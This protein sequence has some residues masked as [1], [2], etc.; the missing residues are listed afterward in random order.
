MTDK[1]KKRVRELAKKS[2][3]SYQAA[4]QQ[5]EGSYSPKAVP[6]NTAL[7]HGTL[8]MGL[9]KR[10]RADKHDTDA[11]LLERVS[12]LA[13]QIEQLHVQLAGCSVAAL[14][15]AKGENDAA[16]G[17]YG[18][19]V[20]FDDVKALRKRHEEMLS[21]VNVLWDLLDDIDTASDIVKGNDQAYRNLVERIQKKRWDTGVVTDGYRIY[22][23]GWP[24]ERAVG[25][26][27]KKDIIDSVG[28]EIFQSEESPR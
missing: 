15:H 26:P 19:S 18:H 22:V 3:M 20:A 9:I 25:F 1:F 28:P 8:R 2:G 5:L 7:G 6:E 24:E 27:V 23:K 14:G 10:L 13:T 11:H 16:P 12:A 4:L 21:L 17:A